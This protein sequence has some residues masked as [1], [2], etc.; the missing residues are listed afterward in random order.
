V[1]LLIRRH[2]TVREAARQLLGI[3]H[4]VG[5]GQDV[6]RRLLT[7]DG[8]CPLLLVQGTEERPGELLL[9]GEGA[10]AAPSALRHGRWLRA[11][12]V[13]RDREPVADDRHMYGEVMTVDPPGPRCTGTRAAQDAEPVSIPVELCAARGKLTSDPFHLD[14]LSRCDRATPAAPCIQQ[15]QRKLS[16]RRGHGH[17]RQA[18]PVSRQIGPLTLVGNLERRSS[19]G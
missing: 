10:K 7:D 15:C 5:P 18:G 4:R 12:E 2:V 8:G 3:D 17:K 9:V 19:G 6:G 14:D 13:W 11:E 1:F 16:L